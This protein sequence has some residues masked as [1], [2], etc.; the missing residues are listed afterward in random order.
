MKK[1]VIKKVCERANNYH[2]QYLSEIYTKI[3][4]FKPISDV[5]EA[6][7]S[8]LIPILISVHL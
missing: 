8:V 7:I 5:S 4:H 2:T 3:K 1:V 6:V